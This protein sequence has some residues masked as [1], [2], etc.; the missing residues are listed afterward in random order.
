MDPK[1]PPHRYSPINTNR[2]VILPILSTP[3]EADGC[4][5]SVKS[6]VFGTR[7]TLDAV[8]DTY[9]KEVVRLMVPVGA[10][11]A[12]YPPSRP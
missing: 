8:S 4:M 12:R 3:A 2:R 6:D 9:E 1:I 5:Q 7:M 10:A 11:L